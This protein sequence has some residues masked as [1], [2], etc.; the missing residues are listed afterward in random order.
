MELK[1]TTLIE[2]MPDAAGELMCEHGLSLFIEFH[3]KKI[4]FDTGQSGDFLK[5]AGKLGKSMK[6]LDAI[7]ISHGHYDHSGGVPA[8]VE[9]LEEATP[10]YVGKNFFLKK[11][12][13]ETHSEAGI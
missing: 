8:L 1:I 4:L 2:N 6:D 11:Y 7:I 13:S 5:N 9:V 12:L 10:L 3:G